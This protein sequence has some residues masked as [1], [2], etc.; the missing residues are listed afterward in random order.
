MINP[1][2]FIGKPLLFKKGINIYPPTIAEVISNPYYGQFIKLLTL[3]QD[4]IRDDLAKKEQYKDIPTPFEF[5]LINC[6]HSP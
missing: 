2:A 1:A 5:L 4:D 3:S 6:Y